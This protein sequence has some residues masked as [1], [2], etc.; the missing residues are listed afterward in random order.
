M[1]I[2]TLAKIIA[3]SIIVCIISSCGT[4]E[5]PPDPNKYVNYVCHDY[6]LSCLD[7]YKKSEGTS[8]KRGNVKYYVSFKKPVGESDE[9]FVCASVSQFLGGRPDK[10]IFQPA[11]GYVDVYRD[12]TIK[13]IELFIQ[14]FDDDDVIDNDEFAEVPSKVL[15]STTDAT[16]FNELA[17]FI[18]NPEYSETY[19][20]QKG[21]LRERLHDQEYWLYIRVYFNESD[22]I[23]WES[24]VRSLI[25]P[26]AEQRR[27]TIDKGQP[28][29]SVGTG[30]QD[31]FID[32]FPNLLNWISDALDELKKD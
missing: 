16:V 29:D 9:Q 21:V 17:D 22:T 12:W 1:K 27:I 8:I 6:H 2:K 5:S 15:S 3:F 23:V 24:K 20:Y 26:Q 4:F 19:K 13:K 30:T 11:E 32:D 25:F 18:T 10:R 7:T 31:V 28:D 14:Y